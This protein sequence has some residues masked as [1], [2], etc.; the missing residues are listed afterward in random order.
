M[1]ER[2]AKK[3]ADN[4]TPRLVVTVRDSST[5]YAQLEIVG[6]ELMQYGLHPGDTVIADPTKRPA[7][8]SLVII[9][10]NG[11]YIAK[12]YGQPEQIEGV[13][14]RIMKGK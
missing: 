7:I 4:K 12:R 6:A 13:I 10:R 8:G 11:E 9:N 14:I 1:T 5:P 3:V 2:D